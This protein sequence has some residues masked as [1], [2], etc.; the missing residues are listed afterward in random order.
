[1]DKGEINY[2]DVRGFAEARGV[3]YPHHSG[4][5]LG[6]AI[7]GLVGLALAVWLVWIKAWLALVFLWLATSAGVVLVLTFGA[8][9]NLQAEVRVLENAIVHVVRICALAE[10][11]P[12]RAPLTMRAMKSMA[13][14]R[15]RG[16]LDA[17]AKHIGAKP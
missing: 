5:A 15:V 14:S 2:L 6:A 10:M 1:M 12:G 13:S 3:V 4:I 9:L 7:V 17:V 16:V 11:T 8:M